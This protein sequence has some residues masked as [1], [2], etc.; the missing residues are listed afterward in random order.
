MHPS[1][2]ASCDLYVDMTMEEFC[3]ISVLY[4]QRRKKLQKA[5]MIS[6]LWKQRKITWIL[7]GQPV[8]SP[9]GYFLP[10]L[11]GA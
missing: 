2:V 11:I 5:N 9:V 4:E 1:I 8:I 7:F 6:S 3:D 10:M